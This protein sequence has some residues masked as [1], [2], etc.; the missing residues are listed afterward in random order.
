MIYYHIMID[1]DN[2]NRSY[3]NIIYHYHDMIPPVN[4]ITLG[5]ARQLDS[6]LRAG[7]ILQLPP[8]R[9]GGVAL[10]DG[11]PTTTQKPRGVSL[12]HLGE[13]WKIYGKI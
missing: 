9:A 5:S 11:P 4:P 7:R 3:N 6:L 13:I 1:L 2:D 10:V 12:V 8:G